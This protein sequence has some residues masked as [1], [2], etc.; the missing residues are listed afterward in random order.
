LQEEVRT[1]KL[2]GNLMEAYVQA[3][4]MQLHPHFLFNTLNSISEL[5]HEDLEAAEKM[6]KRLE[7]FLRLT[8]E[9]TDVQEITVQNELHFLQNYLEIQQVRFQNRLKVDLEID[10]QA[11]KDRVPNLILQ[12]IVENAI[13]H[14]V[15]PRMDSGR[16]EIRAF[17]KEGNLLLQ[18]EDDGPGLRGGGF[19]EGVGM[20]NTR[21]RL[22]QIY[23]KSCRFHVQNNP[24]GGLIVT[25]Q[26]P[27]TV[28]NV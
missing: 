26:I 7:N 22:E 21:R 23:G 6:L 3:L 11:M 2:K 15:S 8:F 4:K 12:P 28:G 20:S 14:G 9:N 5:M 25:L 13:R 27:A 10:P 24:H 1:I 18:V 17:H 19:R 16:V